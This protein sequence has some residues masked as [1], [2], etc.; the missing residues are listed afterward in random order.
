ML[1][2]NIRKLNASSSTNKELKNLLQL[3]NLKSGDGIWTLNQTNGIGQHQSKWYGEAN[4]HLALSFYVKLKNLNP[5]WIYS[6]NCASALAVLKTL[7]QFNVPNLSIKWPNDI[8]S[9][10]KKICGILAENKI[11][12]SE[13]KSIIGIGINLYEKSFLKLPKATSVYIE[14]QKKPSINFFI[15]KLSENLIFYMSMC[16][17][18]SVE[19]LSNSFNEKLFFLKQCIQFEIDGKLIMAQINKVH[20][21]GLIELKFMNNEVK[22]FQPKEIKMI[23]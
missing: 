22:N 7:D 8:L 11:K 17:D 19:I 6:I 10:N 23:Y 15:K 20:L 21:T 5:K 1:Q 16:K 9:G 14:T 2:L 3:N 4:S 13:I 12:G 18:Y